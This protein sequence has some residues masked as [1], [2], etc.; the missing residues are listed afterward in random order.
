MMDQTKNTED[1]KRRE[2]CNAISTLI[3]FGISVLIS[4]IS[5]LYW[6]NHGQQWHML[7]SGRGSVSLAEFT[8]HLTWIACTTD[9]NECQYNTCLRNAFQRNTTAIQEICLSVKH[10]CEIGFCAIL[11]DCNTLSIGRCRGT[12]IFWWD[13]LDKLID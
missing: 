3:V 5:Y 1:R 2:K 9:I 8:Q 4:V 7:Q 6:D 10:D 11:E 13:Y 12:P